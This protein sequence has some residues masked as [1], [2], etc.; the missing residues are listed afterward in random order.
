MLMSITKLPRK[1]LEGQMAEVDAALEAWARWAHSALSGLGWPAWTVIARVMEFGVNGAAHRHSAVCAPD[2]FCETVE[3]AVIRLKAI[4]RRVILEH[5][6]TWQP[7]EI[8][9]K[10]CHMTAGRFRTVL[11]RARRSVGDYLDGARLRY[12]ET[13]PNML[14]SR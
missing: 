9:S 6:F 1:R 11:H 7:V 13:P 4:E 12:N 14:Q 8:T 2:E 10:R 3:R 5:Y